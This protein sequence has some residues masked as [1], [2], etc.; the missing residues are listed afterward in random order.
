VAERTT[1]EGRAQ[2][3]PYGRVAVVTDP[4][5][6]PLAD[7]HDGDHDIGGDP[8]MLDLKPATDALAAIA[9]AVTDDQLTLRTPCE[10]ATVADLLDH[11]DG[12]HNGSAQ[13]N[14]RG[15]LATSASRRLAAR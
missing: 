13:A 9:A 10:K 7:L 8:L 14:P 15:R 3:T 11:V 6:A 2:D 4:M 5:G 12:I 1:E